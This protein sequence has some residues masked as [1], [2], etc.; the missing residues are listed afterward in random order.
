MR[1][2]AAAGVVK[3]TSHAQPEGGG[4]KRQPPA[5]LQQ[6]SSRPPAS[7]G[8]PGRLQTRAATTSANF[9]KTQPYRPDALVREN[10]PDK[11]RVPKLI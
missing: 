11:T 5:G 2:V 3:T 1:V 8:S 6:A 9:W 7:L 4:W 10:L